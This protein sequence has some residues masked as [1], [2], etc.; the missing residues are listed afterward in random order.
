MRLSWRSDELS[1]TGAGRPWYQL[2]DLL[3]YSTGV[4]P[5]LHAAKYRGIFSLARVCVSQAT[6]GRA[7]LDAVGALCSISPTA[8]YLISVACFIVCRQHVVR[9][10]R[11]ARAVG[12]QTCQQIGTHK[13]RDAQP[14]R[15]LGHQGCPDTSHGSPDKEAVGWKALHDVALG[16]RVNKCHVLAFLRAQI[17]NGEGKCLQGARSHAGLT[18]VFRDGQIESGQG[19][20]CVKVPSTCE[21]RA[22]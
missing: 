20:S 19:R 21:R 15:S 17:G 3:L 8:S 4:S 5:R 14:D 18:I 16:P 6:Q 13:V 9:G 11:G 10:G 12:D 1:K 2:Y 7:A 22:C